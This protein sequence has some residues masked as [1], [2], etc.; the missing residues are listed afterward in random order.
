MEKLQAEGLGLG[1][2]INMKQLATCHL[3]QQR[4]H[5]LRH[6]IPPVCLIDCQSDP[7]QP[8]ISA[9]G[10]PSAAQLLPEFPR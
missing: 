7:C 10:Q 1:L 9:L 8:P 3:H 4:G 2:R 5:G 6:P